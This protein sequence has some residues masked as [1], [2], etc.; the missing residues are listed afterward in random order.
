MTPFE[1]TAL[2]DTRMMPFVENVS[3]PAGCCTSGTPTE[4]WSG[5]FIPTLERYSHFRPNPALGR[6]SGDWNYQGEGGVHVLIDSESE[7]LNSRECLNATSQ[8]HGI[9]LAL[10]HSE[11]PAARYTVPDNDLTL[12]I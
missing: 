9:E 6:H 4:H 11:H 5:K 7:L 8:H 2:H 10:L 1:E 12:C 3:P